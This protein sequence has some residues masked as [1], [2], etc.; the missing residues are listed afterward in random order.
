MNLEELVRPLRRGLASLRRRA[1]AL[2]VVLG[3]G[4]VAVLVGLALAAL[5]A[6][7]YVLRLPLS[8]RAVFLGLL[9]LGAA[10]APFMHPE[11]PFEETRR[12]PIPV[13]AAK[14]AV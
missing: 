11:R 5:F 1:R 4:R 9:L 2:L 3:V 13:G 12:E 10:L 7:D 8:V 6:A 14:S